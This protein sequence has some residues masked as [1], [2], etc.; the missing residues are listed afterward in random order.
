MITNNS[1]R[2]GTFC[3]A[4]TTL[5]AASRIMVESSRGDLPV[6]FDG[7]PAGT[8]AERDIRA[9]VAEKGPEAWELFVWDALARKALPPVRTEAA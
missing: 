1:V 3:T 4:L 6:Y 7:R 9:L 2:P 5:R 8:V